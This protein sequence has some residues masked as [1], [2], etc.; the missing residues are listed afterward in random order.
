MKKTFSF[1]MIVAMLFTMSQSV[2]ADVNLN[3]KT[4]LTQEE[5]SIVTNKIGIKESQ[6]KYYSTEVLRFLIA[7]NATKLTDNL[8]RNY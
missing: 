3:N 1:L 6:L 4:E 7:E 5:L 2:F 8:P